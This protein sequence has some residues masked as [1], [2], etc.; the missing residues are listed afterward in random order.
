MVENQY[1]P[2][3][4]NGME[5]KHKETLRQSSDMSHVLVA[6]IID[7]ENIQHHAVELS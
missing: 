7:C 4:A 3:K 1:G 6:C 2:D 5:S